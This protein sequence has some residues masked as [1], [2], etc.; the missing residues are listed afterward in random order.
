MRTVPARRLHRASSSPREQV[1]LGADHQR[2]R[3]PPTPAEVGPGTYAL[4]NVTLLSSKRKP[5]V[6]TFGRS[7]RFA[8]QE[9]TIKKNATPG[10][11]E[12][13]A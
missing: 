9:R 5:V 13:V 6:C 7:D 12:Y 3:I 1:Y 10:P 2:F 11:G 4:G 8:Y